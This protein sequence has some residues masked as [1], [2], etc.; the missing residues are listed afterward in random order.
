MIYVLYNTFSGAHY[1][2]DKIR[3]KMN[4]FF[5]GEEVLLADTVAVDDKQSFVDKITPSDKLVLVGGDGTLNHFVNSVED[6]EYDFDIY[7]YAAGTGND[8]INDVNGVNTDELVHFNEYM[9]RLPEIEVNGQVY[10]FINGIGYG[11]DGWC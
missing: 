3:E 8:F 6:R 1:G 11:I 4:E 5:K 7:C 10:K 9:K 2:K